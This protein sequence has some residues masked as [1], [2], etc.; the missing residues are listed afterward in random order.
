MALL[1]SIQN[2]PKPVL[3]AGAGGA[4]L[5]LLSLIYRKGQ[6]KSAVQ[7]PQVASTHPGAV[8]LP[9]GAVVAGGG[10]GFPAPPP[11]IGGGGFLGPPPASPAAPG[12]DDPLGLLPGR[13][14]PEPPTPG[15][16]E[17][18]P[19]PPPP[20]VTVGPTPTPPGGG[21]VPVQ[22]DPV[23]PAPVQTSPPLSIGALKFL[24]DLFA[25]IAD[26]NQ[27]SGSVAD[28]ITS[29][30]SG[31]KYKPYAQYDGRNWNS[32]GRMEA[33]WRDDNTGL[34]LPVAYNGTHDNGV[35]DYTNESYAARWERKTINIMQANSGISQQE[36]GLA[37]LAN[38]K[39]DMDATGKNYY[40]SGFD[41][42][43]VPSDY[44]RGKYWQ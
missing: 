17:P 37:A 27:G 6:E 11:T 3:Y 39:R 34:Y 36:A 13:G 32:F 44:G 24:S 16:S 21:P 18:P 30:L 10:G 5:G 22:H 31:S 38:I 26:M 19:P 15:V 8:Y 20:P 2:L 28:K 43:G 9:P 40:E 35:G 1:D 29:W 14:S 23:A 41:M 4:A 25:G 7:R 33:G 42:A 12:K